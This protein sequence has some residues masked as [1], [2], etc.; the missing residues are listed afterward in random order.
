MLYLVGPRPLGMAGIYQKYASPDPLVLLGPCALAA[1]VMLVIAG[2]VHSQNPDPLA[3]SSRIPLI[4]SKFFIE[5][6]LPLI[7][8]GRKFP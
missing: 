2:P 4:V 5:F 8:I 6:L 7:L 1:A 3:F